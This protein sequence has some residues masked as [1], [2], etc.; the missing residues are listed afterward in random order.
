MESNHALAV[1]H[2]LEA[3]ENRSERSPPPFRSGHP[4]EL[5]PVMIE[6][7]A[8]ALF[9]FV[10]SGSDRLDRKHLWLNCDENTRAGF[11]REATAV[12]LAVW[13]FIQNTSPN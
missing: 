6:C 13:P 2:S 7:A 5:D 10:F 12:I 8:Q 9:E 3:A 4:A 11:R 1:Y